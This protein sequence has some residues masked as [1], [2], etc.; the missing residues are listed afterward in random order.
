MALVIAAASERTGVIVI[1]P[2]GFNE[3]AEDGGPPACDKDA[4]V[5]LHCDLAAGHDGACVGLLQ[6]D[7]ASRNPLRVWRPAEFDFSSP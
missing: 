1:G 3:A 2:L 7:A 4:P 5:G 6:I